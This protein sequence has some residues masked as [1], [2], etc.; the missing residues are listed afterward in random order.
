MTLSCS[1]W[2]QMALNGYKWLH[3][4]TNGYKRLIMAP[5][6]SKWFQMALNVSKCIKVAPNGFKLA[7]TG[8]KWVQLDPVG[9]KQVQPSA[10]QLM[11]CN[12]STYVQMGPYTF[13]CVQIRQIRSTCPKHFKT[14]QSRC[15]QAQWCLFSKMA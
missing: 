7:Q 2:F 4:V 9:S 13:K 8:F 14:G 15:K 3:M 5:N 10:N 1:K 11:G 6:G 12:G